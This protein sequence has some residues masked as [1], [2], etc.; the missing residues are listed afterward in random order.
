VLDEP[1]AGLDPLARRDIYDLLIDRLGDGGEVTV[2]LS[3]H[4]VG[5]LER[6]AD[7]VGVVD[8][9]RTLR[10]D[11]VEGFTD[12]GAGGYARVQV[13]FPG[14]APSDFELMGAIETVRQGSVALGVVKYD[15]A[16]EQ[17]DRLEADP[18]VRV[19]RFPLTLEEVFVELVDPAGERRAKVQ[20]VSG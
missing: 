17:L 18:A 3:T 5:D 2:L 4:L 6:L 7:L 19:T 8:A 12:M 20:G 10:V 9:G 16:R 11:A 1:A 15:E 14:P 13:I